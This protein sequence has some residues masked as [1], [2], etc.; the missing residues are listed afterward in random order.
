MRNLI[1]L[2]SVL[3]LAMSGVTMA[4]QV[5]TSQDVLDAVQLSNL[6]SS[7]FP[8]TSDADGAANDG[9]IKRWDVSSSLIGVKF[10]TIS[11]GRQVVVNDALNLLESS[12]GM[13]LFDR[14]SLIGVD[15]NSITRGLVVSYGTSYVPGGTSQQDLEDG[16]YQAGVSGAPNASSYPAEFLQADGTISARLYINLG[17]TVISDPET[18]VVAHEFAHALGLGTHF[19]GFGLDD[20]AGSEELNPELDDLAFATL[21]TLYR[22]EIGSTLGNITVHSAPEAGTT[23]LSLSGL[24]VLLWSRTRMRTGLKDASAKES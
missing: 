13:I 15:E 23:C 16:F 6:N 10:D 4:S 24:T 14:T 12:I 7:A 1:F 5:F 8:W 20:E 18:L 19:V 3:C 9:K 11:A 2:T 17:N 22:N 21:S